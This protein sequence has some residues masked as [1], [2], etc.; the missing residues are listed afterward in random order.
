MTTT[1]NMTGTGLDV[2]GGQGPLTGCRVL[3]LSHRAAA[4][5][6]RTLADLGA[7]VVKIEPPG[8]E[9]SRA[10]APTAPLP[11]GQEIGLFWL[12]FNV[13]KRSV[14]LAL[15]TTEGRRQ[16]AELAR[17]ADVV[18]TDFERLTLAE[19]DRLADLARRANPALVWTEI[20]PFGRGE[21]FEAWPAGDLTLQALGG[22]LLLNGDVDRPPVRL[23]LPVALLQGG[24]EA[25][26]AAVMAYYHRLRTGQ[27]QRVD[28][29]VQECIT[30]TLLNTTMT[31]QLLQREEVRGGAVRKERAN[32][33]YTRLVWPVAD[34]FVQFGPVGGGGGVVRERSYAAL[35]AWMAEDGI[36]DPLLTERDWNGSGQF[37]VS[38]EDYDAVS[39]LIAGFL[40]TKT[41]DELMA[42][43][44]PERI[45]L[46]PVSDVAQVLDNPHL[47]TRGFFE[48]LDDPSRGTSLRYPGEWVRMTRTPLRPV[49]PAPAPG[50]DTAEILGALGEPADGG[51][52]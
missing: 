24:A 29:S 45:L 14:T 4:V 35:V 18:V 49:S 13:S 25:A 22:H 36:A 26:S 6:G 9:A 43:A 28:V 19:N 37:D 39:E 2:V 1:T 34:G 20:W 33:F 30:W 41:I 38:Q 47:V 17:T 12:A 15:D 40:A 5:A 27:G 3:E 52:A 10:L 8:G 16:F 21:P 23:G 31:W 44:V 42:R 32:K 46:A 51:A 50:Q 48:L 7:E 11:D